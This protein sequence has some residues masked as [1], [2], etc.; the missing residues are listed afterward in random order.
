MKPETKKK[1]TKW[2]WILLT[3]PVLAVALLILA[4]A[5]FAKIPSF[6]ELENPQTNLIQGIVKLHVY[7]TPPSPAQEIDFILEYDASYVEAAFS[8]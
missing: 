8:A 3:V 6:E 5:L 1:I 2:F 7:M 4:V